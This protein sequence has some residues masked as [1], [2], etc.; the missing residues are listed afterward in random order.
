MDATQRTTSSS[1]CLCAAT[2]PDSPLVS[3]RVPSA[4]HDSRC[5]AACCSLAFCV[6]LC[7]LHH[8]VHAVCMSCSPAGA[9]S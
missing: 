4:V 9:G 8:S 6:A 3:V 5:T 2:T 1:Q 7:V